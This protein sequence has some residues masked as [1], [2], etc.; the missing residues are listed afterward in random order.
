MSAEA[1]KEPTNNVNKVYDDVYAV[2]ENSL[3]MQWAK[4]SAYC[5]Q[6]H[7][8]RTIEIEHIGIYT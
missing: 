5:S 1:D 2:S 7:Q 8:Q 4:F 6:Q 3:H